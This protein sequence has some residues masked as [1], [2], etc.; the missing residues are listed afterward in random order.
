MMM[1]MT[2]D[3][4]IAKSVDQ[5]PMEWSSSADKEII[6]KKTK[7][8]GA[9]IMG[10][11][12]YKTIGKP[13]PGRLNMIMTYSPEAENN[14]ENQLE[15]TNKQPSELLKYLSDK[16]FSEVILGGGTAINSLFLKAGLVDEL[17]ITIEPLLFGG[18]LTL[19]KDLDLDI[20]LE[21]LEM[22]DLGS[23]VINLR[24][25]VLK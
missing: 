4:F 7:E 8:G 24:Y 14:I 19:F 20:K 15:Y 13:L 2:A 21:L 23:N 9:I 5:S 17:Q 1:V 22:K 16:G 6:V 10:L 3:G 11:S 12:T 18:G 25:K